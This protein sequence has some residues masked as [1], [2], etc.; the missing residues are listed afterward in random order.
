[1]PLKQTLNCIT[2]EEWTQ[3]VK[4]HYS[5][6]GANGNCVVFNFDVEEKQ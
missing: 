4:D 6:C 1:M 2:G 5:T 3:K